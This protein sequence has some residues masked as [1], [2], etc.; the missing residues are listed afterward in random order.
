M[1]GM[2]PEAHANRAKIG[3][4]RTKLLLGAVT[5]DEARDLAEP[6]IQRMN[7]RGIKISKKFGLKFKPIIFRSLMR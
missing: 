1:E 4:I 3:E 2:T 5:Y 6:Y 7:K